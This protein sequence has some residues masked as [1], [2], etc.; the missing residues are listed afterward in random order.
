MNRATGYIWL[1][2]G[3]SESAQLARAIVQSGL[4][5]LVTVT[6]ET[7]KTLYP[8]SPRLRVVVKKFSLEQLERFLAAENIG[9]ILDASHP[10]AVEISQLAI[11]TA[12]RHQIPYLRFERPGLAETSTTADSPIITLN[13]FDALLAGD[14]LQRERVLLTVGY[15]PLSLFKTWHIQATL[16]AR[17]LPGVIA[18]EAALVAGFKPE[19][20]FAMRPPVPLAM[21]RALWQHWQVSCVVTKAS[22][23][24]GG[25][26]TKRLLAAELG[27][28]LI[29]IT[30]PKLSY[31]Q[32]TSDLLNVLAFCRRYSL[33]A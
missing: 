3:T 7:A 19:H 28:I 27:I 17:I 26:D 23:Q 32:Q 24:P 25:E 15:K 33:K 10:Y 2:G 20:L 16:F 5:C 12:T 29:V 9:A 18:L 22:G 8:V 21:E 6:T 1:I 11:A 31:P 13:S 30:R 14:Y 4:S